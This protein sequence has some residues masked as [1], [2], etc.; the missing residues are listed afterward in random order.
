MST[1]I[2][3]YAVTFFFAALGVVFAAILIRSVLKA[4]EGRQEERRRFERLRETVREIA[5]EAE[6][7]DRWFGQSYVTLDHEGTECGLALQGKDRLEI[8]GLDERHGDLPWVIRHPRPLWPLAQCG[9]TPL[10]RRTIPWGDEFGFYLPE[11]IRGYLEVLDDGGELKES[12]VVLRSLRGMKA[13]RLEPFVS[14]FTLD[15][16]DLLARP[17]LVGS[18]LHHLRRVRRFMACEE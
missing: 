18:I 4:R 12:L 8:F 6:S 16:D 17:D 11:P 9:A 2:P 14:T 3:S 7:T 5:G 13:F 15:G 10:R 1:V